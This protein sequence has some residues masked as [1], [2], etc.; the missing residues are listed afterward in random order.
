MWKRLKAFFSFEGET[1]DERIDR[2]GW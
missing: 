1:I 2:T